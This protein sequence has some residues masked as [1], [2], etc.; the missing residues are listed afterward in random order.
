MHDY[1]ISGKQGWTILEA[2]D[3]PTFS[4]FTVQTIS[5]RK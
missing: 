4:H 5:M 2:E 3:T 1:I